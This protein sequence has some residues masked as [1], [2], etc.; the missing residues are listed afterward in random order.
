MK[1]Q[2]RVLEIIRTK[3]LMTRGGLS[4]KSVAKSGRKAYNLQYRRGT[5]YFVKNVPAEALEAYRLSTA[6]YREFLALVQEYVDEESR[7]AMRIIDKE[8]K[9][10]RR[11]AKKAR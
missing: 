11:K 5:T 8:A 2:E 7:R 1:T 9:D 10:A 4:V 3:P 6:R